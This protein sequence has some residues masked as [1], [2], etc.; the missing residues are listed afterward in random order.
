MH[1]ISVADDMLEWKW[2]SN[3][4]KG[5]KRVRQRWKIKARLD[6]VVVGRILGRV[7]AF[8]FRLWAP[9][10]ESSNLLLCNKTSD[11]H[12]IHSQPIQL[13]SHCCTHS[14]S[15]ITC[16]YAI[17]LQLFQSKI[18]SR[19]LITVFCNDW[20]GTWCFPVLNNDDSYT[21]CGEFFF[22]FL[23]FESWFFPLTFAERNFVISLDEGFLRAA[24]SPS[25]PPS[26]P[27]ITSL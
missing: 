3:G 17:S 5:E 18:L 9:R 27:P 14:Q 6:E 10:N 22:V 13:P 24:L 20:Y 26:F 12:G 16:I 19:F 8:S 7:F 2:I 15:Q 25:G 11:A 1:D 4:H 23:A 21:L